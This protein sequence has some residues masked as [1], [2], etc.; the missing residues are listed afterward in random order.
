MHDTEKELMKLVD[1]GTRVRIFRED[2]TS[3][4]GN[5][6]YTSDGQDIEADAVVFATGWSLSHSAI[7]DADTAAQLGLPVKLKDEDRS[8]ESYWRNLR[9]A[10]EKIVFDLYPVLRNPPH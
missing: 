1:E 7:F 4:E 8:E 10:A 9:S 3:M 2:I 5:S 6:V